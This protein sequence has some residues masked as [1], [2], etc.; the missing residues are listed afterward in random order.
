MGYGRILIFIFQAFYFVDSRFEW[1]GH[2]TWFQCGA[3]LSLIATLRLE[4]SVCF[5]GRF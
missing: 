1:L 3:A 5:V 2:L 4:R